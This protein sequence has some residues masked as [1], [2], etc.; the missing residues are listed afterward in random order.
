MGEAKSSRYVVVVARPPGS[1][2]AR[3]VAG[4]LVEQQADRV[5]ISEA[6][7]ALYY[8]KESNGEVGLASNGPRGECRITAPIPR[9]E[10]TGVG[11]VADCTEAAATA[12]RTAP[13][14]R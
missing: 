10:L 12:W 8:A 7:Q 1:N 6:R 11:L 5:V 4:V 3:V 13:A 2:W 9:L 14:L